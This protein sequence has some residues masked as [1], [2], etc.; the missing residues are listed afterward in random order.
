MLLADY[1]SVSICLRGRALLQTSKRQRGIVLKLWRL[2]PEGE[3]A[4]VRLK[5]GAQ[6]HGHAPALRKVALSWYLAHGRAQ[7][8]AA[9]LLQD[10]T[11]LDEYAARP[12]VAVDAL[13]GLHI[14]D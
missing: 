7:A 2:D 13:C 4:L 12:L 10:R 3:L 1:G 9:A 11:A 14:A 5:I 6:V 8:F